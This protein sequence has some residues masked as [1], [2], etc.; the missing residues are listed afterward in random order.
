MKDHLKED[1]KDLVSY[2]FV[3]AVHRL[4]RLTSGL[5]ILARSLRRAQQL[6]VE[7]RER[8]VTKVYLCRVQGEFLW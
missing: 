6:E 5:L 3:T 1:A 2:F 8:K 7:I 4:D